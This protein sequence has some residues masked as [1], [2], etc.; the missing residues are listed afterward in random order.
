MSVQLN[1]HRVTLTMHWLMAVLFFIALAAV[2]SRELIEDSDLCDS[3]LALH[4]SCGVLLLFLTVLRLAARFKFYVHAIT[5]VLPRHIRLI[6]SAGH[7][8]IYG[9]LIVAPL[10]GWIFASA[11][12]KSVSFFGLFSLPDLLTKNRELADSLGELHEIIAYG[13]LALVVS[14]ILAALWHH[15]YHKDHIL[16]S[17]SPKHIFNKSH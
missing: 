14:H 13:F 6:A 8:L 5:A 15:F 17:I 1:H 9:L 3:L 10:S 7:W 11:A 2:L 12:G 16:L 4:K